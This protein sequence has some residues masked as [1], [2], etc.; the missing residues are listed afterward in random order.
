MMSIAW[1]VE[2]DQASGLPAI[3]GVKRGRFR[4]IEKEILVIL[5]L[6]FHRSTNSVV[7]AEAGIHHHFD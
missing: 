3:A 4:V 1:S 6:N 5:K 7:N 2:G